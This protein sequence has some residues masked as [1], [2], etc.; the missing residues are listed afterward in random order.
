MKD[1]KQFPSVWP[2]WKNTQTCR[3]M[4]R[5]VMVSWLYP[6]SVA[7][8]INSCGLKGAPWCDPWSRKLSH[9]LGTG[10]CLLLPTC[11][12]TSAYGSHWSPH[13]DNFPVE[14][15][16]VWGQH[17]RS[18]DAIAWQWGGLDNPCVISQDVFSNISD[19]NVWHVLHL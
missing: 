13:R 5:P 15:S 8:I 12:T 7:S 11:N 2:L 6:A 16:R 19:R 9:Q 4:L 10:L 17:D 3:Y 1:H 14:T 18:D